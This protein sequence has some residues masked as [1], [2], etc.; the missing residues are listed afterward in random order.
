MGLLAHVLRP[1]GTNHGRPPCSFRLSPGD[2][3]PM[4]PDLVNDTLTLD[5]EVDEVYQEEALLA[6]FVIE[7]GAGLDDLVGMMMIYRCL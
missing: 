1:S 7:P 4:V 3:V 6:S 2:V 5:D